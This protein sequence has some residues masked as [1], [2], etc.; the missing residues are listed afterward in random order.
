MTNDPTRAYPAP[1]PAELL[2]REIG[3]L[4]RLSEAKQREIAAA[5]A[6]A[7]L[8]AHQIKLYRAA[9]DAVERARG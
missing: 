5:S 6:V 8:C 1:D 7:E 3:N 4:E 9:L 2:K